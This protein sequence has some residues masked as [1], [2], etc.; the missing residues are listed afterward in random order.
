MLKV[1]DFGVAKRLHVGS[2]L[3]REGDLVGTPSYMAPEQ[4]QGKLDE[5]GPLTDVYGLGAILYELLTGRPPFKAATVWRTV[6]QVLHVEPVAPSK[7]DPKL[8]ADLEA[9]C[10][11]CLAKNRTKRYASA[12][13]LAEDLGASCTT[14]QSTRGRVVRPS[15][16]SSSRKSYP[17]EPIA[18]HWL[19]ARCQ[20]VWSG[21]AAAGMGNTAVVS[22]AERSEMAAGG[23]GPAVGCDEGGSDDRRHII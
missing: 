4:A 12:A 17:T 23:V 2:G 18:G 16:R 3:T 15:V 20:V 14:G 21:T 7:L 8:P 6:S 9:I 22:G 11:K 13:A 1:I 19:G 5:I 10:L